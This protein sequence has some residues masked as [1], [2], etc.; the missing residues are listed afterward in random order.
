MIK[1]QTN[2]HT[3]WKHYH[4]AITGDNKSIE[5]CKYP[6]GMTIAKV[7]AIFKKGTSYI[8][9]NY[10][11]ISLLSSFN[12]IFEKILHKNIMTFFNK[13]NILFLY[14]YG[15]R[16]LYST[17]FALIEI[18]DKMKKLL[19]EENYVIGIYLDLTKAFDTVNHE[20]LLYK[21]YKYGICGHANNFFRSYFT[22]R[23]Q[24]TC[25]N[26]VNSSTNKLTVECH[27]GQ[28]WVQ[29]MIQGYFYITAISII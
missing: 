13:H 9:D 16:K 5:D 4:L 15:F 28:F 7:A 21:L 17:T 14:Q 29:R 23:K 18:T 25:I 10:R 8:A 26:G 12:K 11:P 20:I 22:K 3:G 27:R 2:K 6:E 1:T 24:Y 19:D